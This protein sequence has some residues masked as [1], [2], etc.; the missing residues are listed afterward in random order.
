MQ[1]KI[2]EI[3]EKGCQESMLF[4][5]PIVS[6]VRYSATHLIGE[7]VD[8][9][10]WYACLK[11]PALRAMLDIHPLG[12]TGT[13]RWQD[14]ILVGKRS[15]GVV[16]MPGA[17]ECCPSGS[18]DR[19]SVL[20]DGT[21]DL[22]GAILSELCDEVG[23]ESNSVRVLRTRDLYL[24]TDSGIFDIHVDIV[25][26]SETDLSVLKPPSREYEE[27]VW[28]QR[29]GADNVFPK[30]SWVPLSL[31]LLREPNT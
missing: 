5:S 22:R 17:M 16:A 3:W 4:E 19:T 9:S 1:K 28:M 20:L 27:L 10:A 14:A 26:H 12:V 13:T 31:H 23:I 18:I 21:V 29:D 6:L 30:R 24:S 8:F 15:G 2:D 25:L 11:D 7:L